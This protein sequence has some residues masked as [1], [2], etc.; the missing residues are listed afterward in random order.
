MKGGKTRMKKSSDK[1][2]I[3]ISLLRLGSF[4]YRTGN[5]I[6]KDYDLNQQQFIV[7]NEI[8]RNKVINQQQLVAELLY[9]KS[10]TSKIVK[11]LK[12]L[13]YI[14]IKKSEDDGRITLLSCTDKGFRV[15]NECMEKYNSWN[16][17]WLKSLSKTDISDTIRILKNLEDIKGD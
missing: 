6:V 4:L 15:W 1:T 14:E 2:K 10:N 8:V 11:K 17:E 16:D 5:R 7:L 9:E 12:L 3:V 13:E